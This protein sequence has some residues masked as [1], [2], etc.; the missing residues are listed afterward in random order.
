MSQR[1][2]SIY[3]D[4]P[5][6]VYLSYCYNMDVRKV[7]H[8]RPL[9]ELIGPA[10]LDDYRLAFREPPG[11]FAQATIEKAAGR[12]IPCILWRIPRS[13]EAELA[14]IYS[15]IYHRIELE[16]EFKRKAIQCFTYAVS[17]SYP[18]GLPHR[19][20]LEELIMRYTALKFS[21]EPILQACKDSAEALEE[22]HN[23]GAR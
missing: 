8:R 7:R 23:S 5:T 10:M 9:A 17:E 21:L 3:I 19:D 22:A 1:I 18:L 20:Y 4:P 6:A 16:V 2:V 12:S 15:G 13:Y 14:R 11:Q